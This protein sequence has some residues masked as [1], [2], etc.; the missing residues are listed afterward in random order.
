MASDVWS[1]TSFTELR[2][3][4]LAVERKNRF[5]PEAAVEKKGVEQCLDGTQGPVI[6]ASD[7]MRAVA[8]SIRTWVPRKYVTLGTDGYGRS[9][10]RAALRDF[11]EVDRHHVVVAT[12]RALMDEGSVTPAIV[13]QAIDKYG[14]D[15]ERGN[16]WIA[17]RHEVRGV[18]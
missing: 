3:H 16:P 1:V 6:A 9:D 15:T 18:A 13:K 11:F 4:G 10:S 17:D 8:D 12:L 5:H 14:L 2:R 7:Y